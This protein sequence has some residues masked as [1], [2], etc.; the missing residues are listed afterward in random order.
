MPS[1]ADWFA[2]KMGTPPAARPAEQRSLPDPRQVPPS[3][4]PMTQGYPQQPY[5]DVEEPV[6]NRTMHNKG[7]ATGYCPQ[8]GGGDYFKPL[9]SINASR[10]CY[11]CNYVD[12]RDFMQS[13]SYDTT[14]SAGAQGVVPA[15]QPVTGT[16]FNPT[17][18][19]GKA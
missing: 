16:G 10:R 11:S 2:R 9:G 14:P 12:G 18:I 15:R 1:S 17:T 3:Q 8:C 13:S 5:D 19:V 6:S 7:Q 4:R